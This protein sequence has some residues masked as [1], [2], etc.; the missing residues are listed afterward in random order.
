MRPPNNINKSI[1][2][3][4]V[5]IFLY[6]VY[7]NFIEDTNDKKTLSNI[8]CHKEVKLPDIDEED[9]LVMESVIEDYW[10]KRSMNKS[11]CSKILGEIKGG[12]IRGALGGAL[13]GEGLTGAVSGA[14]VFGLMSGVLKAYNLKYGQ[15]SFLHEDKHT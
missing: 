15:R 14:I 5:I 4:L 6:L 13:V 3:V 10:K 9:R 11:N 8:I 1:C 12:A 7:C 2:L